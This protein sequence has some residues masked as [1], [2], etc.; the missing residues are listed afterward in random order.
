MVPAG[1]EVLRKAIRQSK[2]RSLAVAA[3]PVPLHGDDLFYVRL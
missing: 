1:W 2:R 3:N